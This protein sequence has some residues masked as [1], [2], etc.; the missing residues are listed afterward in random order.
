MRKLSIL[1]AVV[2][3]LLMAA[4]HP[5]QSVADIDK[6]EQKANW[7]NVMR[8]IKDYEV[9]DETVT[10]IE[11]MNGMLDHDMAL[12]LLKYFDEC[13]QVWE[14]AMGDKGAPKDAKKRPVDAYKIA[15]AALECIRTMR[16][17]DQVAKFEKQVSARDDFSL[18]PRMAMMDAL[19]AN[20]S[21]E[22]CL[23]VL[24]DLAKDEKKNADTDMR[25]LA[26]LSLAALDLNQELYNVLL[27]CLRDNSWRVRDAA[28][29][30]L[31][32][33]RSFNEDQTILALINALAAETG[34]MRKVIADALYKITRVDNGTD[35]DKWIDW[36]KEKKREEQG[37]PARSGKGDRGTRV[38]VFET[39]SFSD[40][41]VFV[42]DTSISMTQR[43][44]DEEK[45]KLKKS[46]TSEP[47]QDK[48]PR[49]P[50]DWSKINS[51]LDLAREEM[52]RSL[53]VM[54]PERTTFTIITFAEQINV[55]KDELVPTDEKTIEEAA[56]WLRAIKG[57]KRTNVFGALD[58]AYDLS[59]EL[60]GVDTAK[61]NKKKK[62]K[63]D[64]PITGRHPDDALPDTIFLYT[65]GYATWGKYSGDDNAWAG[66]SNEE[67]ARLYAP[68][69]VDMVKEIADRNRIARI[70]VNCV[71]VGNP[72]DNTT[73]RNLA[74]ACGGS[75]VAIGK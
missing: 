69:M 53:E 29:Q 30:S 15:T 63:K 31:V 61:R 44:T 75:Y 60:A 7:S 41:Y 54:D 24:V 12:E 58:A 71:G 42:L 25:I 9:V 67:K 38:K 34:K 6:R 45:E 21:D 49:R 16:Q 14:S 72:Q 66:K 19:A 65:D 35:P 23:K 28:V 2:C 3:A 36:F 1:G 20:A 13:D 62:S 46:I 70:T 22:D 10:A 74:R 4:L 11:S 43:I 18:R 55:W 48:D 51:K 26:V 59:E 33:A 68:I 56:K 40:R 47:G 57:Q 64:G 5:V 27:A 50:L 17:A 8:L 32:D 52:I 73:L 37:L 39:E